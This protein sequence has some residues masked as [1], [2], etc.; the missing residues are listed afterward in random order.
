MNLVAPPLRNIIVRPASIG[1]EKCPVGRHRLAIQR[2]ADAKRPEIALRRREGRLEPVFGGGK[3]GA[4]V[5]E[6]Q[7]LFT[8]LPAG[9]IQ[10]K[11]VGR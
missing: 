1:I 3:P 7:M 6:S 10:V 9:L 11:L 4:A 5:H 2:E 8:P